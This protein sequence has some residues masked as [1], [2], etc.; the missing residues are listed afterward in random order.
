MAED[1]LG[2]EED[3]AG[4]V[5]SISANYDFLSEVSV[6]G[7]NLEAKDGEIRVNLGGSR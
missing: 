4:G 2:G 1:A 6:T 3:R 7:Y 5:A